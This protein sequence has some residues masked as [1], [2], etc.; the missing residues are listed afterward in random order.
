MVDFDDSDKMIK[1]SG[2]GN[3]SNT[4]IGFSGGTS[5]GVMVSK[6]D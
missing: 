5:Y 3:K 4:H 2:K 6:L 1:I